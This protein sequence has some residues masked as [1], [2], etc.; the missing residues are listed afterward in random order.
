VSLSQE[1]DQ[2]ARDSGSD[3]FWY[4]RRGGWGVRGGPRRG[5]R[6]SLEEHID[7][8]YDGDENG[9]EEE[10]E[11]VEEEFDASDDLLAAGANRAMRKVPFL[12]GS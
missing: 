2:Y 7:D 10:E 1:C 11:E 8:H 9:V 12:Y 6:R 3:A 5:R 4:G